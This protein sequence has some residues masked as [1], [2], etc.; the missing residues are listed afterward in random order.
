[1]LIDIS[2]VM[3]ILTTVPAALA[4]TIASTRA[5]LRLKVWSDETPDEYAMGAPSKAY[6]TSRGSRTKSSSEHHG[7]GFKRRWTAGGSAPHGKYFAS[8]ND[9]NLPS[10]VSLLFMKNACLKQHFAAPSSPRPFSWRKRR[11]AT[12]PGPNTAMQAERGVWS[13]QRKSQPIEAMQA[14]QQPNQEIGR[15]KRKIRTIRILSKAPTVIPSLCQPLGRTVTVMVV[16]IRTQDHLLPRQNA[17]R[18]KARSGSKRRKATIWIWMSNRVV[19]GV[20]L[21]DES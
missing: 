12:E 2:A 8:V 9:T 10:Y 14:P 3:D 13:Y 4:T 17:F 6:R 21:E 18:L 15:R 7:T 11:C 19:A 16:S 1:M 5:V 20:E